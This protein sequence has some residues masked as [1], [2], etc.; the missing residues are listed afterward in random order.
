[1]QPPVVGGGKSASSHN[2]GQRRG[3]SGLQSSKHAGLD[4]SRVPPSHGQAVQMQ[5]AA[6]RL[7]EKEAVAAVKPLLKPLYAQDLLVRHQF[8]DAARR[9]VHLLSEGSIH[10]AQAAVKNALTS[11]GL[12]LA[13]S[14][15]C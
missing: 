9:A 5:A 13:A 12:E 3:D 1:M 10:N 2:F 4:C 7:S 14:R 6:P 8:K 11:M 15:L